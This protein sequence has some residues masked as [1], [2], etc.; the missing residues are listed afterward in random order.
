MVLKSRFKNNND[1]L[2]LSPEY[3]LLLQEYVRSSLNCT[4]FLKP[5][6]W[7][8]LCQAVVTVSMICGYCILRFQFSVLQSFIQITFSHICLGLKV[9]KTWGISLWVTTF[10][11]STHCFKIK[12]AV[13]MVHSPPS[14]SH[15]NS[16]SCFQLASH[17][18]LRIRNTL[19]LKITLACA[20]EIH[21]SCFQVFSGFQV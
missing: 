15:Q 7:K 11:K 4:Q 14:I 12:P 18:P 9:F 1:A 21:H 10:L 2:T 13:K 8:N 16:N 6:S 5:S 20:R 19:H 17:L 3:I